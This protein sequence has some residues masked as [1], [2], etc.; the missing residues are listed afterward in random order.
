MFWAV[1]YLIVTNHCITNHC[2]TG[3]LRKLV[4]FFCKTDRCN[5]G[6]RR[7]TQSLNR[8]IMP[9]LKST[10]A[11]NYIS[12]VWRF[13]LVRKME[14]NPNLYT[15]L[16]LRTIGLL[17]CVWVFES[18]VKHYFA[19][20][21]FWANTIIMQCHIWSHDSPCHWRLNVSFYLISVQFNYN[22]RSF[23]LAS[24]MNYVLRIDFNAHRH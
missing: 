18:T 6:D 17:P 8:R 7:E 12:I 23:E 3:F 15:V 19:V 5:N 24:C 10:D 13:T 14:K 2:I 21:I 4:F 16:N 20:F 11:C 1:S 9:Y 22:R